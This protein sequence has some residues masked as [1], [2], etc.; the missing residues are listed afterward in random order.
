MANK[1]VNW[2]A[3]T[4]VR[5]VAHLPWSATCL[6]V[7]VCLCAAS[8]PVRAQS[9][10]TTAIVP[11]E[12][13]EAG[14]LGRFLFGSDY[15]DLWTAEIEVPVLD[16]HG[17]KGGLTPVR[18]GGFGQTSSLHFDGADGRRHIFRSV[19]KDPSRRL[20]EE[21]RGT[22]VQTIVQDQ[23]AALNP[24][25]AVVVAPLLDA[26]G[27]LN[28]KPELFAM[29]DD[30]SLGEFRE[31]F[32]GTLG[33]M[34]EN[35]D[36]GV[37]D[38]PGFAGA[39]LISGSERVFRDV[40]EG[41]DN[42]FNKRAFL[43]ARLLDVFLGDRDRHMGQW[44]W[45]RFEHNTGFV[46][47]PIPED[48]DQAFINQDGLVM[49]ATR[50]FFNRKYV[51]FGEEY[52]A[53]ES[54]TWNGWDLDRY[55]LTE[56][57]M[58]VWDSVAVDLQEK[59]S[60]AVIQN[61]VAQL[62]KSFFELRGADLAGKLRARRDGLSGMAREFYDMLSG[63]AEVRGT[64][65]D[66]LVTIAWVGPSMLEVTLAPKGSNGTAT[67]VPHFSRTFSADETQEVRIFMHGGDDQVIVR[68]DGNGITIRVIGGGGAD[69]MINDSRGKVY[70]YDTGGRTTFD[71]GSGTRIDRREYDPPPS[72][73]PAH[74]Q[75]PDWGHWTR[76]FPI[77][78]Y[79]PDIGLF[80][81]V[82]VVDDRY[83][84]RSHPYKT[85]MSFRA[86]WAT[87]AQLPTVEFDGTFLNIGRNLHA[88]LAV[89]L[90]GIKIIRFHGF[91]N[92]TV[93]PVSSNFQKVE[94][95]QAA[96]VPMLAISSSPGF[97]FSFGPILK[98][99]DTKEDVAT[100]LTI[101]N[102]YG[103]GSFGQVGGKAEIAID[104][105]HVDHGFTFSVTGDVYPAI[106]DVVD[107]FGGV[108]GTI[109]GF[110]G[111]GSTVPQ[112]ALRASGRKIWGRFPFF[113]AAYIGGAKT[114]RGFAEQRFAGDASLYGNAELRIPIGR[115]P[116]IVPTKLGL[117]GLGD[118]GRVFL[119]GEDSDTWH[120]AV[121]GGVFFSVIDPANTLSVAVARST[122]R[123][124]VY[125]GAG[126]IF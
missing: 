47:E 35:P 9:L 86:A 107:V 82:G 96:V 70:F 91:G 77:L 8:R 16:L 81:G 56:L 68:G 10:G 88:N 25:A 58:S 109:S 24:G 87:A 100:Q 95:L 22:F 90:S 119:D 51:F 26:A 59:L 104:V 54:I 27:V 5:M 112:L 72:L 21:L 123:T 67:G 84:F 3:L 74:R 48:R 75:P 31:E 122:E 79:G 124:S 2:R 11:G 121:G 55:I 14:W 97:S 105:N 50:N 92:E 42:R 37:N 120:T 23:I 64:D 76:P 118:V 114:L 29:P 40:E 108:G 80:V 20:A 63:F 99:V 44:R 45:A 117:L 85:K 57:P 32:A 69:A 34:M 36:E 49:W 62:P 7:L 12:R 111:N 46:W 65:I 53:I 1:P 6:L 93:A 115:I 125:I 116:F 106:W 102:P 60:D 61:A 19:D 4:M 52:P 101:E 39:R 89:G 73:D 126:F 13:Y 18:R 78:S 113:E 110:V 98:F 30:A 43:K 66:E 94:Q 38:T 103:T 33:L 41:P 17:Y 71:A 28:S 83:G 15:R